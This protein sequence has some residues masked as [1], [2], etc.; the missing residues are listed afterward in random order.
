MK[1]TAKVGEPILHEFE[2]LGVN[3]GVSDAAGLSASGLETTKPPVMLNTS[4]TMQSFSHKIST[5]S[6]DLG[7][8]LALREDI[9]QAEGFFSALIVDRQ[10]TF[11]FDPEKELVA[12]H[13]YYGIMVAATEDAMS[14]TL[15]ADAGNI[16]TIS[17]PKAQYTSVKDGSRNGIACY[18]IDGRLNRSSGNDEIAIA[19]T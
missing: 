6:I 15:G 18:N 11:S 2:F 13:D 12:T 17:S 19:L 5:F 4:F 7:T 3:H 16:T 14:F 8:Q 10:A 9:G 1:F